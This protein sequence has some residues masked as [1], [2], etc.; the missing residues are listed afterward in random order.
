MLAPPLAQLEPVSHRRTPAQRHHHQTVGPPPRGVQ[1][2]GAEAVRAHVERRRASPTRRRRDA[3]WGSGYSSAAPA[4]YSSAPLRVPTVPRTATAAA[5]PRHP[6]GDATPG[7][8]T[9]DATWSGWNGW[10]EEQQQQ[11]QQQQQQRRQRAPPRTRPAAAAEVEALHRGL[12]EMHRRRQGFLR[13]SGG[14][15]GPGRR[16]QQQRD[17]MLEEAYEAHP[18]AHQYG[19]GLPSTEPGMKPQPLWQSAREARDHVPMQQ[20]LRTKT[21]PPGPSSSEVAGFEVE[22]AGVTFTECAAGTDQETTLVVRNTTGGPLRVRL[23]RKPTT[24][25]FSAELSFPSGAPVAAGLSAELTVLCRGGWV[26][27]KRGSEDWLELEVEGRARR[28]AVPLR[29]RPA[30]PL[31]KSRVELERRRAAAEV[32]A[33]PSCC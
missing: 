15:V 9:M 4:G 29:A 6:H 2:R 17:T 12:A 11:Q 21:H 31:T 1:C 22:P 20:W 16:R 30:L 13:S 18:R 23:R 10:R 27:S 32:A 3:H 24:S 25:V 26:D 19:R 33:L 14:E 7:A 8:R 5:R 28:L